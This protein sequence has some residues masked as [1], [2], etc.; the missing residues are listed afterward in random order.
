[1]TYDAEK[2]NSF[3]Q[4]VRAELL[5]NLPSSP[6]CRR[7]L[8]CGLLIN[9]ECGVG[10]SVYFR[11]SDED[12]TALILR[13]LREQYSR[14]V[15]PTVTNCYGR[16]TAE[17][18]VTLEKLARLLSDL[19]D[20]ERI[21]EPPSFLR[22]DLCTSGFCAGLLLSCAT[23]GNPETTPRAE[24]RVNDPVRAARVAAL[25]AAHDLEPTVS[26]RN[27]SGCLLFKKTEKIEGIVTLSGAMLS[28]MK[29]IEGK[30]MRE[31]RGDINRRRNCD[32][33]NLTRTVGASRAQ[34]EA[35]LRLK[36][37]GLLDDLP[38]ELRETAELRAAHPEMSLSDLAA[39]H[40]PPISKSGLNHRLEKL[41]RKAEE[42]KTES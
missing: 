4:T 12:T 27:G 15:E 21:G 30:L 10:G 8:L 40:K 29:M 1:M 2:M 25:L 35:V 26:A 17:A 5:D 37:C 13:L 34:V 22:C 31:L 14:E 18:V 23:I 42:L 20:P 19:S 33:G 6:C 38:D 16:T 24:I 3:T 41:L 36:E 11:S 28:A 32:M 7:A 9:S 39:A